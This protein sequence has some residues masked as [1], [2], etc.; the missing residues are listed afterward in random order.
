[1]THFVKKKVSSRLPL[2]FS[3]I[4]AWR[5][6]LEV[7]NACEAGEVIED[8]GKNSSLIKRHHVSNITKTNLVSTLE[9]QDSNLIKVAAEILANRFCIKY[10]DKPRTFQGQAHATKLVPRQEA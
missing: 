8:D 1:M 9:L 10:K 4:A 3:A 6:W 5:S 7:L 2:I